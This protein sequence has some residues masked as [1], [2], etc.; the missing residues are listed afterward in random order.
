ML[1]ETFSK[2][3]LRVKSYMFLHLTNNT[4]QMYIKFTIE[5]RFYLTYQMSHLFFRIM[6]MDSMACARCDDGFEPKAKIVN[7]NGELYHPKCFV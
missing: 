2:I 3:A 4:Y 7:S 1:F 5:G 6:N